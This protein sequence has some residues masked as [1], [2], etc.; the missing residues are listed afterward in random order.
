MKQGTASK[1]IFSFFGPPGSGKGTL[2]QKLVQHNHFMMLS[3]GNLCREHIARGTFLGQTLDQYIKKGHLVPDDLIVDMVID[4][5]VTQDDRSN[6]VVLDGFPRT[7]GQAD[8]FCAFLQK[9]PRYV[10]R[11]V[12]IELS[13]NDIVERLSH[14]L[15]CSNKKCQIPFTKCA[16]LTSCNLCGSALV[17][18]DDDCE[19]VARERLKVY[20]AYRDTLLEFYKNIEQKIEE[21]S[22]SGLTPDMVYDRFSSVF[23]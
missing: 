12:L 5:L 8:K 23:L 4:W 15:V 9:H 17:K 21:L 13:E 6:P 2:A 16:K 1:M 22:I 19:L 14:R 7:S 11:V 10:F 3:T 20:P 18:R